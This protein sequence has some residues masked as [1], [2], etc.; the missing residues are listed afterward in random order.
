[1]WR[2]YATMYLIAVAYVP[3]QTLFSISRSQSAPYLLAGT[4][5][6]FLLLS[7]LM[8]RF[9]FG[10]AL[11]FSIGTTLVA[12][13]LFARQGNDRT[14]TLCFETCAF[15]VAASTLYVNFLIGNDEMHYVRL[16]QHL[17]MVLS[18]DRR[19]LWEFD[20]DAKVFQIRGW[21]AARSQSPVHYG[22]DD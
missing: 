4:C 1:S 9:R 20:T 5:Y 19:D 14:L 13:W 21:H 11:L 17:C 22:Y 18:G 6:L 16:E 3:L 7:N 15:L 8:M 10:N 12:V 2:E